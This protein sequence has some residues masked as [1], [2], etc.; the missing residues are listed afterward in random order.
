[1][2]VLCLSGSALYHLICTFSHVTH[3]TGAPRPR[4]SPR[5]DGEDA[6]CHSTKDLH[7]DGP[8]VCRRVPDPFM[9][10][11]KRTQRI[12]SATS[13]H[14]HTSLCFMHADK[15]VRCCLLFCSAP[16]TLLILPDLHRCA[17]KLFGVAAVMRAQFTAHSCCLCPYTNCR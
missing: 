3:N 11:N 7:E 17:R 14:Q 6:G 10:C 15:R 5:G 13:N 12:C 1:M 9:S 16:G 2:C 4:P 8:G